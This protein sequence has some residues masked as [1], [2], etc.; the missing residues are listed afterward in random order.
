MARWLPA[1]WLGHGRALPAAQ[2]ALR[3]GLGC[4]RGNLPGGDVLL[5]FPWLWYPASIRSEHPSPHGYIRHLQTTPLPARAPC[6]CAGVTQRTV[7]SS[8]F[9]PAAPQSLCF[10]PLPESQ[11]VLPCLLRRLLQK[12][13][14]QDALEL[15]R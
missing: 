6:C 8:A 7:R 14:F 10:H 5:A 12:G 15:A 9:Q 1:S 11:P 3:A 4:S 13:K 2:I